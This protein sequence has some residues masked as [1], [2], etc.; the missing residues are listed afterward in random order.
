MIK[1]CE[2]N[3]AKVTADLSSLAWFLKKHAIKDATKAKDKKCATVLKA[4][5]RDLEVHIKTLH[6]MRG[7]R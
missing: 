1:N 6:T 5:Q 2:Y 3:I 7:K 4:L